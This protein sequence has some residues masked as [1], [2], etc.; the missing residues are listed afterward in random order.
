MAT[1][2]KLPTNLDVMLKLQTSIGDGGVAPI[3]VTFTN[4]V[5]TPP[6]NFQV[7]KFTCTGGTTIG[8]NWSDGVNSANNLKLP[9]AQ[10]LPVFNVVQ[11]NEADTDATDL[12]AWPVVY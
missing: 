8:I 12:I 2:N 7:H 6:A 9:A 10:V 4:G 11:V 3:P 1:P 5:W